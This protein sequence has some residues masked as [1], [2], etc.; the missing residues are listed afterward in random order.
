MFF[1]RPIA[2]VL[3]LLLFLSLPA[4]AQQPQPL[5][6]HPVVSKD[7]E[8]YESYLKGAFKPGKQTARQ[9]REAG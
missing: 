3:G 1:T 8:R 5:F 7:A 2:F 9:L 6:S 4:L